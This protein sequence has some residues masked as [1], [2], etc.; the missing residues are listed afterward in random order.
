[1]AKLISGDGHQFS[2]YRA[3]PIEAPK[4][5]VVVVQDTF[6]ID[7]HI[8]KAADEFAAHGYVAIAP[9]LFD[10][11]K[12]NVELT[13][14]E[15]GLAE[16]QDLARQ[17]GTEQALAD[18]QA[19]VDAVKETGKVAIVGYSWGG[20]L[21]YLSGNRVNGLACAIGY[22][23]PGIE[24]EY[25]EKRKIPTLVHFGEKD[26]MIPFEAVTQFRAHRPDVST[27]SYPASHGFDCGEDSRYDPEANR[28]ALSQTLFWISQYVVGQPPVTL[29]NA[30][31]YAQQKSEKKKTKKKE[32]ADDLGPPVN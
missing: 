7:A 26:P 20:Y 18:I 27:F 11:V 30:G 19:A 23:G 28:A 1:M 12:A 25:R 24:Q 16:G 4:G 13:H 5:A 22:Y 17:I 9:A 32:A 6:G 8:R 2:A 31:A 3:D 14:D 10:R 15:S 21:A 29:K